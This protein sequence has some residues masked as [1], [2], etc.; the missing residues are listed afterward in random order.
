MTTLEQPLDKMAKKCVELL[1]DLINH[2]TNIEMM[3]KFDCHFVKGDT[4]K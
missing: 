3:N 1:I 4:T 2:K